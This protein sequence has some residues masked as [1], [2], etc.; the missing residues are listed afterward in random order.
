MPSPLMV[1]LGIAALGFIFLVVTLL[2]GEIFEH[3]DGHN[4]D[5]GPS[6]FSPRVISVFTTAFGASGAIATQYGM[7][8]TPSSGVGFLSG[9]FFGGL[10]YWFG[11]FLMRQQVTTSVTNTDMIGRQGMV[12]VAIPSHGVGQV[13]IQFG[14]ELV[15]KVARSKSGDPIA[16]NSTV[17]VE[18][19][20][21]EVIIVRTE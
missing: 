7:D 5:G 11:V 9:L 12:T 19:V 16:L 17:M 10:I 2:F 1:F 13:R 6:F 4:G 15:D 21:G 20:L 18:A 8:A 3:F 14:E